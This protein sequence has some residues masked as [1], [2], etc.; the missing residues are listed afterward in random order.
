[1]RNY[2]KEIE[3][4]ERRKTSS[5]NFL[6]PLLAGLFFIGYSGLIFIYSQEYYK[7]FLAFGSSLAIAIPCFALCRTSLTDDERAVRNEIREARKF[8]EK[9]SG[10]ADNQAVNALV[11]LYRS[12]R[13]GNKWESIDD[14]FR[15]AFP[16]KSELR[17]AVTGILEGGK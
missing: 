10:K 13:E 11:D 1:M 14:M 16:E 5:E 8:L 2:V 3:F 4:I 9:S 7:I 12:G 15:E 17:E 6:L